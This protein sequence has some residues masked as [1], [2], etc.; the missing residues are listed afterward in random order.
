MK[1]LDFGAGTNNIGVGIIEDRL[2]ENIDVTG[3]EFLDIDADINNMRV[4]I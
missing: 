1:P 2:E 3:I 4:E